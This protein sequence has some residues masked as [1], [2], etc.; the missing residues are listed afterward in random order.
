MQWLYNAPQW[1]MYTIAIIL[2]L[3]SAWDQK[4]PGPSR[5]QAYHWFPREVIPF[6]QSMKQEAD[7]MSICIYLSN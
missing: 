2:R 1:A 5:R 4:V 6:F 3:I 7:A